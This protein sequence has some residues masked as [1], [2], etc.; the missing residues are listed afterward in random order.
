VRNAGEEQRL[1]VQ[2]ADG[3]SIEVARGPEISNPQWSPDG[4]QLFYQK[5]ASA[6]GAAPQIFLIASPRHDEN[7][8]YVAEGGTTAC[9]SPDGT[10]IAAISDAMKLLDLTNVKTGEARRIQLPRFSYAK[11]LDSSRHTGLLLI[12]VKVD[13][14]TKIWTVRPDGTDVRTVSEEPDIESPR[15]VG[16]SIYYLR[17]RGNTSELVRISST[18]GEKTSILGGL[19]AGD[20]FTISTDG[21]RLAYTRTD[22]SANLWRVATTNGRGPATAELKRLTSG[23]GY[24]G[25]PSF[26][27][28][29]RQL[30][31]TFGP[32]AVETNIFLLP[33]AG[34][35]RVQLTSVGHASMNSPAWSP[36]G[37]RIAFISN[38]GGAPRVP[39]VDR[40]GVSSNFERTNASDADNYLTWSPIEIMCKTRRAKTTFRFRVRARK[41][42]LSYKDPDAWY[43]R[44]AGVFLG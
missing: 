16:D 36:D 21:S 31:F 15:W 11:A 34:G 9:W 19:Q 6:T 44:K 38:T 30:A 24:H 25:Q 32:N 43:L 14:K 12:A 29:G 27:P 41:R 1:M 5:F 18:G 42:R 26:S 17:P 40:S 22:Y 8:H 2:G 4:S 35:E 28:D 20:S 13:D 23:T 33:P 10:E 39:L 3:P 37:Q 7:P